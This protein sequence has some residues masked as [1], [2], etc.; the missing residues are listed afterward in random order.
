[1]SNLKTLKVDL[2]QQDRQDDLVKP[3]SQE[4]PLALA[5]FVYNPR[6]VVGKVSP[7]GVYPLIQRLNGPYQVLQRPYSGNYI[8]K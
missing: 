6:L 1:M 8:D 3:S 4:S 7:I 2:N 5:T